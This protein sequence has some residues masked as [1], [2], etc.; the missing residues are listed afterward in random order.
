MRRIRTQPR[1]GNNAPYTTAPVATPV[2]KPEFTRP[3]NRPRRFFDVSSSVK[4]IQRLK[5]PAPPRPATARPAASVPKV[6]AR[7][8]SSDPIEKKSA[9]GSTSDR[10]ENMVAKRP[11]TGA[12]EESG[13]RYAVVNHVAC[14]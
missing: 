8:V 9:I 4:I 11:A 1:T 6:V 5:T 13:M 7:E 3:M 2:V 10:G 12:R 14:A